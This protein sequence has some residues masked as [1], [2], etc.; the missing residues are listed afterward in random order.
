VNRNRHG[1]V[2][3][4]AFTAVQ[5]VWRHLHGDIEVTGLSAAQPRVPLA[6][7][8]HSVAIPNSSRDADL[9]GFGSRDLAGA[10]TWLAHARPLLAGSTAT[11]TTAGKHHVT[12]NRA[13]R[14]GALAHETRAGVHASHPDPRTGPARLS[15]RDGHC[16][17][18]AVERLVKRQRQ[19]LM[20]ID[21]TLGRG[22]AV[23]ASG[24]D[25]SEQVAE[26]G[27]VITRETRKIESFEA[28]RRVVTAL[29]RAGVVPGTPLRIDQR[30]VRLEDLPEASLG[31][32]VAWIDIRVIPPSEPPV[33]ALDFRFARTVLETEDDVEV[34]LQLLIC[35]LR[36]E[37][38]NR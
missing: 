14:P 29:R 24:E 5:R 9:H 22:P 34:H 30:L 36:F 4:V 18:R 32:P 31:R 3:I 7:H 23:A 16:P 12:P 15:P 20:Q 6:G 35:D 13:H 26:G 33:R 8:A 37:I 1:D 25:F 28:A 38:A 10:G 27:R 19:R 17:V 2:Q 11:G 21:A